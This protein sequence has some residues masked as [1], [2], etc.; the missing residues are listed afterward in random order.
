[1]MEHDTGHAAKTTI[2]AKQRGIILSK[3]FKMLFNWDPNKLNR[4]IKL[5]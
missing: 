3:L 2:S 4:L 1:M 5:I